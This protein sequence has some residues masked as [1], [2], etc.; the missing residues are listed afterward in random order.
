MKTILLADDS[1]IIQVSIS[2]LLMN[3]GYK[4]EKA[5][6]GQQALDLL[7]TKGLKPD[8]I[9]TDLNMPKLNGIDL[10]KEVR[11]I[12]S[13]RFTPIIVLTTETKP[14]KCQ[15]AKQAGAT[16]WLQKPVPSEELIK[17]VKRLLPGT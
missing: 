11:K 9:I 3:A 1:V 13:F 10:V 12:A 7:T 17:V 15:A 5:S 14:E 16:G 4:V 6:D 8:L 2:S